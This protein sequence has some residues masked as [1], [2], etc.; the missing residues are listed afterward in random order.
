MLLLLIFMWLPSEAGF[1]GLEGNAFFALRSCHQVFHGDS[2]EFFSP[3]YLCSSPAL[4]CNWTIQV[5]RDKRVELYLEDLTP[6]YTCHLKIDQIHLDESPVAAGGV[7]ILERCWERA[8]YTSISNTVHVVQLIGP[9]P[10]PPHRGF[11]GQYQAFGPLEPPPTSVVDVSD[12][13]AVKE[14]SQ[15]EEDE[16][17]TEDE[18]TEVPDLNIFAHDF[19]L[20]EK[21]TDSTRMQSVDVSHVTSSVPNEL[22]V[23]GSL[24]K[25]S[26][27]IRKTRGGAENQAT[28]VEGVSGGLPAGEYRPRSFAEE[29]PDTLTSF[30]T[31][32]THTN[33]TPTS[34]THT[35]PSPPSTA[36]ANATP[37][38]NTHTQAT[39]A[40]DT[41]THATPASDTHTHASP[42]S[43]S[44]TL[45]TEG[46][47]LISTMSA[48]ITNKNEAEPKSTPSPDEPQLPAAEVMSSTRL[49]DS[50]VAAFVE[51]PLT[52][53]GRTLQAGAAEPAE[54]FRESDVHQNST[55]K[56]KPSHR[57]KGK[58]PSVQTIRSPAEP[59][60]LPGGLLLEV[61]VEIGV[62]HSHKE[63]WDHIRNSFRNAVQNM[64]QKDLQNLRP[65]SVSSKRSKKLNAGVLMIMW[66]Q[67]GENDEEG[68]ALGDAQSAL[69]GLKGK[70]IDS[71]NVKTRGIITSVSVED[72]DECETQLVMCDVH[73]ECVN[74]FGSYS[75]HCHH[76]YS[77]GL[78]GA[79]CVEPEGEDCNRISFPT[80]LYVVCVLLCFLIAVLLVVLGVFYRRYHRGAF[81][82]HCHNSI[83]RNFTA[84]NNNNNSESGVNGAGRAS[85]CRAPPPPPPLRLSSE[86]STGIDLPL[87]KF[88]PLVPPER[89]Q[90]KLQR[91]KDEP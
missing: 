13:G 47:E 6:E 31:T 50:D 90:S 80:L 26:G 54:G 28:T 83:A 64:I 14:D 9:N 39:P 69:H 62:N 86:A 3:D 55:R 32:T 38:S 37:A 2:G 88:T 17:E 89:F 65:K 29:N 75:C 84:T 4:W 19:T 16:V 76:G 66:V 8:R 57:T 43:P 48:A 82:P 10:N 35:N 85:S 42:T 49:K 78:G 70:A 25:N 5:D 12:T 20:P 81:L 15:E 22:P 77:P 44:H 40:S 34:T 63:S 30:N 79:V 41:H 74:E 21:S 87:L 18:E 59:L 72:I 52:D 46:I 45:Y 56:H 1:R 67:F 91:E 33:A 71:P 60:H 58:S 36:Q 23:S 11:Y 73:A 24:E 7:Q 61:T 27:E 51:M 53:N 68:L